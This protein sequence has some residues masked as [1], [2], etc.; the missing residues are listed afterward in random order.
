MNDFNTIEEPGD[1]VSS[2]AEY[3]R[4]I[5]QIRQQYNGP[6]GIGLEGHIRSRFSKIAYLDYRIGCCKRPESG[7]FD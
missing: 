4:K 5:G 2:P 7:L 3:I 6:L 1:K